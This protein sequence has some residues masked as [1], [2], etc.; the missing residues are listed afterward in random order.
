MRR[1]E[2]VGLF[3]LAAALVVL[4]VFLGI[5]ATGELETP[6]GPPPGTLEGGAGF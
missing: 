2:I 5:L 6:V 4:G 1:P 3:F